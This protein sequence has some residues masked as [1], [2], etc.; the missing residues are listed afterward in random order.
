MG[1]QLRFIP[2]CCRLLSSNEYERVYQKDS[3]TSTLYGYTLEDGLESFSGVISP[4]T[5]VFDTGKQCGGLS[6]LSSGEDCNNDLKN[7]PSHTKDIAV[8]LDRSR[9][10]VTRSKFLSNIFYENKYSMVIHRLLTL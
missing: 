5:W 8:I 7:S 3:Q 4:K 9:T 2:K 1:Q 6:F 10:K